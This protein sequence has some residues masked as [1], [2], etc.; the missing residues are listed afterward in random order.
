MNTLT[1]NTTKR[2]RCWFFTWNNYKQK[3]LEDI[4]KWTCKHADTVAI[5]EEIGESGTPHLQG[6]FFMKKDF[7]FDKL[8]IKWPEVH[9]EKCRRGKA[10]LEYCTKRN[11]RCGRV[12]T[13]N[14]ILKIFPL[15]GLK[16]YQ[17]QEDVIKIITQPPDNRT[18][19]WFWEDRG[20]TGKTS[21]AKQICL[22]RVD[23]I[24]IS[25]KAND[26][27]YGITCLQ[28]KTNLGVALFDFP[29]SLEEF[30][31]YEA[32]ESVKNGIFFNNKYESKMVVFNPPHVI[33]FANF[34]PKKSKL[35]LDRWC[36]RKI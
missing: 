27:K 4:F 26:I 8:K 21:L 36:I 10:A 11:T 33:C 34:E 25:G 17:W 6:C 1:G 16:L 2:S 19:Y 7:K 35:S 15:D 18:I 3:D 31:S 13:K 28:E 5:Q 24:Y 20:C 12:L 32:L 23:A 22:E 30:V 29:R 14:Y 9:W